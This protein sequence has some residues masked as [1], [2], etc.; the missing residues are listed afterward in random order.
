MPGLAE[1]LVVAEVHVDR[2]HAHVHARHLDLEAQ[3]DAFV[4]LDPDGEHI[5]LELSPGRQWEHEVRRLPKLNRDLRRASRHAFAGA[6]VERHVLPAP[7]VDHEARDRVG[8]RARVR[9]DVRLL[10]VP[11]D[12]VAVERPR[13]VLS[14]HQVIV[15]L[16][17]RDG[18]DRAQHLHFFIAHGIGA[19]SDRRL[20]RHEREQLQEVVLEHVAHH[21]GFLVVAPPMLDPHALGRR[22]LHVVHVLAVP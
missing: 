1:R 22:D 9:C 21:A 14:P 10:A 20:H 5:G 4:R 7:I 6:Q 13:T 12:R 19:E 15:H 18:T 3:R 17:G 8:G 16:G 2:H 11:R